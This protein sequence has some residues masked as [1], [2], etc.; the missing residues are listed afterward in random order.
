MDN[1]LIEKYQL[2]NVSPGATNEEITKAFKK[3]AIKYHPDKNNDRIDWANKIMAQINAAYTSIMS[4]RFQDANQPA[5]K[6]NKKSESHYTYQNYS[7]DE[8][9]KDVL[10]EKLI[11]AF[12]NARENIKDSLYRYF[13]YG[14]NNFSER[15][16]ISNK[17]NFNEIVSSLKKCFHTINNLQSKTDDKELIE[18]FTIFNNMIL[19]FYKA[20]ECLNIL[21]SYSNIVD[22]EAYRM[23]AEGDL[24]L[25]RAH[26]EI[27]YDRHN[28]GFKKLSFSIENAKHATEYFAKTIEIYP[29]S[30][31]TV[32]A[33]IKLQ[34]STAFLQY[35]ELFF[36]ES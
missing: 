10:R 22:V 16:K 29:D 6:T 23:Y 8:Y 33:N 34:Y 18:H 11:E 12:V 20:S 19:N 1:T 9:T 4:A 30:S 14:L 32:E 7:Y 21:D 17:T 15:D 2:L 25:H 3:L 5:P 24:L 36:D 35:L 13:Q 27:F 26:K 28:R 31:W